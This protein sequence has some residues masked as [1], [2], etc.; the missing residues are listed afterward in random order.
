MSS[1]TVSEVSDRNT[2]LLKLTQGAI[3]DS[4]DELWNVAF[5]KV[6]CAVGKPVDDK[7]IAKAI[8]AIVGSD[9][10]LQAFQ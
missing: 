3:N 1:T 9:S 5:A 6:G 7:E 10:R 2:C 8:Q 4:G